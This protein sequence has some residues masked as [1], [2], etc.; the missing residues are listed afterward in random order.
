M[1]DSDAENISHLS[2]LLRRFNY[3]TFCAPT[4]KEALEIAATA[5]PLLILISLDCLEMDGYDLMRRFRESPQTAA[6]PLIAL[7]KQQDRTVRTRCLDLGAVGCLFYPISAEALYR[8]VQVAIEKNPRSCMR[9]QTNQPVKVNDI[10][11]DSLY[12]AYT[13]DLSERG[14]F[15]RTA[16][17]ASAKTKLPLQLDLNGRIINTEGEVL[18]SCKAGDEPYKEPGI[19]LKFTQLESKDREYLRNFISEEVARDKAEDEK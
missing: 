4:A 5:V 11:H 18:Y 9:I 8:V 16:N 10:K 12:G 6:V 3:P 1:I 15:L 14:M 17:P 2:A 19:G 7:S 13:L